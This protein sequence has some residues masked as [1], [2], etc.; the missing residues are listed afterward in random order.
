MQQNIWTKTILHQSKSTSDRNNILQ[1][2]RRLYKRR[3]RIESGQFVLRCLLL[4]CLFLFASSLLLSYS[5]PKESV[6]LTLVV[7]SVPLFSYLRKVGDFFEDT[8]P[9]HSVARK[10]EIFEPNFQGNLMVVVE[11]VRGASFLKERAAQKSI[12][13]LSH[14]RTPDFLPLTN[15]RKLLFYISA[16]ICI[17]FVLENQLMIG[18]SSVWSA[19]SS[20][21]GVKQ[22][23]VKQEIS[24]SIT[25]DYHWWYHTNIW[26]SRVHRFGPDHG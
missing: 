17:L 16:S 8:D 25:R 21:Y 11:D 19:F 10:L 1:S 22:K 9:T 23:D 15:I 4:F 5:F 24:I 3:T 7:L 2:L 12:S 18:P 13:T 26:L 6:Y 14:V 20:G